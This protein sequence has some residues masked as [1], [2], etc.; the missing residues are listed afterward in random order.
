MTDFTHLHVHSDYS[1]LD[2]GA[3]VSG[4]AKRAA[5]LGM[6]SLA[7][8]DHGNM[9]G[10]PDF[11]TAC[12]KEGIK[13]ILGSEIYVVPHD[14][15]EK[16]PSHGKEYSHLVLL[17]ENDAGYK[18]LTKIVSKAYVH[19]FYRKP[20]ADYATLE[21][22]SEGLIALTACLAGEI[23]Q[24]LM[25]ERTDDARCSVD[26][27]K[28]IF[29]ANNLFL[30]VQNH[31]GSECGPQEQSVGGKMFDLAREMG[32]RCAL[33]NDSHY[34]NPED[35]HAHNVLLCINT[36]KLITDAS[37][38]D[39]G[40]DFYLKSPDEMA[41]CYP[42]MEDLLA[43]TNEIA[44]RCNTPLK[45]DQK[46]FLPSFACPD[47]FTEET[48]LEKLSLDG[49]KRRY[50]DPLPAHVAERYAF[51]L[52][53]VKRMG[54]CSYFLITADFIAWARARGIPVGPGRGSAAGSIVSYALGST[55]V[56]PLAYNLLFERFLNPDRV[57]M[58]DIDIDF[59]QERRGEVIDYVR[60]KYGHDCVCQI[61]TFGKLLSR[62][63]IK[64]VGRVLDVP[65]ATVNAITKQIEVKQGKVDP[66]RDILDNTTDPD[67]AAAYRDIRAQYRDDEQVH[68]LWDTARTLEGLNRGTGIHAAGIVIA[69]SSV[70]NYMPLMRQK[71]EGGEEGESVVA[72]QYTM[73]EVEN[74]GLL[75]M[76]FLGLRNL[77]IIETALRHI[78]ED[79][80]TAPDITTIPLDDTKTYEMLA[81]GEGF[82]V[83]QL[84]SEGMCKL[85]RNVKP[86]TF[87]DI[88]AVIAIY[89]PGPLGAGVDRLFA[90]R[91]SG[92]D[93]PL[94]PGE[95]GE[96]YQNSSGVEA[97]RDKAIASPEA[98]E[99][100]RKC[101]GETYGL[102]IYQ[103]QAM[104]MSRELGGFTPGNADKL[105]KA[106]GKKNKAEMEALQPKFIEGCDKNGYGTRLGEH[107]WSLMEGFGAYGFNKAHTVAY[108]MIAY[109]TA[110][111][112]TH[113]PAQYGAALISSQIG[114]NDGIAACV[115]GV[116][117]M[118]VEV[119][120]PDINRS[121][122]AFATSGK[123]VL[124]GLSGM[125]NTG[126]KAV[127][128]LLETRAK[129][130]GFRGFMHFL[131]NI[132]LSA[133]GKAVL[134]SLI[135][136][137]AFD[138][139]KL[140]RAALLASL[141]K[142]V[143]LAAGV[144]ADKAR[145]QMNIFGAGPVELAPAE[146][147][148]RDLDTLDDVAEWS[149]ADKQK[150]EK[151]LFGFYIT[152]SPLDSQADLIRRCRTH[153][154]SE[155]AALPARRPVVIG[156][157]VTNIRQIIIKKPG[158]NLGRIMAKV[159]IQDME[160]TASVTAFPD[161]FEA[162]REF[163]QPDTVIFVR[164]TTEV[165]DQGAALT[166][167]EVIPL[168][169]ATERLASNALVKQGTMFAA[170]SSARPDDL[171]EMGGNS[172]VRLAGV[173]SGTKQF[174][175]QKGADFISFE[176]VNPDGAVKVLCGRD[177]FEKAKGMVKDGLAFL[178][179]G[180]VKA[181]DRGVTMFADDVVPFEEAQ[182][183]YTEAVCVRF[184]ASAVNADTLSRVKDVAARHRGAR[185]LYLKLEGEAGTM[186]EVIELPSNFSV[187]PGPELFT[188]IEESIGA[189]H[190]E[191]VAKKG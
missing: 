42:G 48:L 31:S 3:T 176:I 18:N 140:K 39:Y 25:H 20:R 21:A 133:I 77:T 104:L 155:L 29:G 181:D 68:A 149:E 136:G 92:E 171:A 22:H 19:G 40:P 172:E 121:K 120:P 111:L 74:Q 43:V 187:K 178:V 71:E 177:S 91:K 2:G 64:D 159:D 95:K 75:K 85:L 152:S 23:P 182:R 183:R 81:R 58:P 34:L 179:R 13:P 174:R 12:E 37:R 161:D 89:R 157:L 173:A 47:G 142:C 103:E 101:L 156:G 93:A 56:D 83:F 147:H 165:S 38:M 131:E 143:S 99:K 9:C 49:L 188:A 6:K 148:Q 69:P 55:S 60:Q 33:T 146:E 84:E 86:S 169:A 61:G 27:Y 180:K 70:D 88:S 151:E 100:L 125:K 185:P 107:L 139:M 191:I 32:L 160:G 109:Q 30:E 186:P 117:A 163:I 28:Q 65:L 132:D 158:R 15:R 184:D 137:G 115:D 106:I 129:I 62:A 145:G 110:W 170:Y 162:N 36:G 76:D 118:G 7:L 8:T 150:A 59:C 105:R 45:R 41:A 57:S 130:G 189:G 54:F 113:Y 67:L 97:I 112:K 44:A 127:E 96:K 53:T 114:Y 46:F 123:A 154:T 167:G 73:G 134:E 166:L 79:T 144:S 11:K 164:G 63:V 141:E 14:M 102:L 17:A 153:A 78:A 26:R 138:S 190:L 119:L 10:L 116:R 135:R 82:G 98:V 72:T 108:G 24:A 51:E 126:S 124:F 168:S 87:E 5:K 52:A 90:R 16:K 4:L 80:G 1:F 175:S 94:M 50:G 128:S 122:A 66:I 35:Y